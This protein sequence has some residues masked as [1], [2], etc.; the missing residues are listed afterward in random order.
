MDGNEGSTPANDTMTPFGLTA[1][2]MPPIV[3]A[4]PTI[5]LIQNNW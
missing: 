4:G 2:V 3:L 1:P 5:T